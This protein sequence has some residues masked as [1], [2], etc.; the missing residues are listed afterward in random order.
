MSPRTF[1]RAKA[2]A[3]PP[4]PSPAIRELTLYPRLPRIR[5]P[6]ITQRATFR[7]VLKGLKMWFLPSFWTAFVV[8]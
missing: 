5:T 2:I 6:P 3:I 4:I 8:A 7:M 1:W